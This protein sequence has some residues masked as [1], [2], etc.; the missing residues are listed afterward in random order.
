MIATQDGIEVA[1]QCK[2][3]SSAISNK[4]IQEVVSG[5][6]HYGIDQAIVVSNSSYTFGAQDLAN[7]N[8]VLL[9]HHNDLSDLYDILTSG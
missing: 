4:A 8:D 5:A 6:K 9:L 3:S 7:T 2:K 1:I